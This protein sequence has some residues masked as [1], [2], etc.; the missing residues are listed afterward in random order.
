[1]QSR[2]VIPFILKGQIKREKKKSLHFYKYK[3]YKKCAG[4]VDS[5]IPTIDF[6]LKERD[7]LAAVKY[8]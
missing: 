2:L 3:I 4:A 1:M 5:F 7:G 8:M 6:R